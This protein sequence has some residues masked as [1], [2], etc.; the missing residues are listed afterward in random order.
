[1]IAKNH[2]IRYRF[3]MTFK[4]LDLNDVKKKNNGVLPPEATDPDKRVRALLV[5]WYTKIQSL[6]KGLKLLAWE[7]DNKATIAQPSDIPNDKVTLAKFFQ[8]INPKE[9][10]RVCK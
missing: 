9:E 10:G 3:T 4:K 7:K 8:G 5:A 1:M 2:E 6:D